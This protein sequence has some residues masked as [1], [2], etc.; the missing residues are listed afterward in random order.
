MHILK[1]GS[2]G[3]TIKGNNGAKI[4]YQI[5]VCVPHPPFFPS[6]TVQVIIYV[7]NQRASDGWHLGGT[8]VLPSLCGSHV[9][10]TCTSTS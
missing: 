6:P 7:K 3:Q 4:K 1:G 10:A 5:T 2:R 9:C 8:D